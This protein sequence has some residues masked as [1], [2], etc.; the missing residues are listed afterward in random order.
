[1]TKTGETVEDARQWAK[2]WRQEADAALRD[3]K[4]GLA[5][6][7]RYAAIALEEFAR[8]LEDQAKGPKR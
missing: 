4:Y 3:A 6:K 7:F 2:E 1:M 5:E 8:H